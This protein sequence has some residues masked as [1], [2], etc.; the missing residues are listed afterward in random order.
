MQGNNYLKIMSN[1]K[2]HS[3]CKLF[4]TNNEIETL[5]YMYNMNE[6]MDKLNLMETI[7]TM[8]KP[9]NL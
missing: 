5:K 7:E 1:K 6:E 9:F 3:S 4:L 8:A 2:K